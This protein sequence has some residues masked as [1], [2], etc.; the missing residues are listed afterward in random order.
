MKELTDLQRRALTLVQVRP[1]GREI[2]GKEIAN[3]IGLRPRDTGKEGADLRSVVNALRKKGYP[4]CAN[5][6]GYY[7]P[8]TKKQIEEYIDSLRGRIRKE[9]EALDG[10]RDGIVEWERWP[11]HRLIDESDI[12]EL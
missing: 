2:T 7:Y 10:I 5:G 6:S 8:E 11:K 12:I 1:K 9:Q 4:I 3:L